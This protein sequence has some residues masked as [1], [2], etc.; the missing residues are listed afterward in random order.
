MFRPISR[1]APFCTSRIWRNLYVS[2]TARPFSNQESR[3][4]QPMTWTEFFTFRRRFQL[5]RRLGG[6]PSVIG[7]W[8]AEGALLSLPIFDPTRTFYDV[9]PMVLVGMLTVLG[10]FGSYFLG[11][12]MTGTLW[13][14]FKSD[15]ARSFEQVDPFSRGISSH[16]TSLD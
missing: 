11:A 10:S 3:P 9:D 4:L 6:V 13:R 14:I 7:F 1:N 8:L 15:T 2:L 5:Y 16:L 12:S